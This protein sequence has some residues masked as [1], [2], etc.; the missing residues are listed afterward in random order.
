MGTLIDFV[1]G[2]VRALSGHGQL[3]V[4][5]RPEVSGRALQIVLLVVVGLVVWQVGATRINKR[6]RGRGRRSGSR[7]AR[8]SS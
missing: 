2:L 1:S 7:S 6:T 8:R 4:E 5:G 3:I